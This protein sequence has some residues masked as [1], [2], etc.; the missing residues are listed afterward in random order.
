MALFSDHGVHC[1]DPYCRQCDFLPFTCEGCNKAFCKDHFRREAHACPAAQAKDRRVEV[2]PVCAKALPVNA[3]E[4]ADEVIARHM[5]SSE[6]VGVAA[7]KPRCP[8]K[9]CKEKLTAINSFTCGS[10]GQKVCMK[11]RFEDQHVCTAPA[12]MQKDKRLGSCA[13]EVARK[14]FGLR[15]ANLRQLVK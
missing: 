9:G 1:A 10:C 3:G 11:H 13:A 5:E 8:A 12:K 14:G 4:D 6:C 2:C 7:S 15:F